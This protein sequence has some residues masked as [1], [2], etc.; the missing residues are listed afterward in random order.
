M[1]STFG[2]KC[3]GGSVERHTAPA[4]H[5]TDALQQHHD[6]RKSHSVNESTSNQANHSLTSAVSIQ[7][8]QTIQ[9][10]HIEEIIAQLMEEAVDRAMASAATVDWI[11][12]KPVVS[13]ESVATDTDLVP[14]YHLPD[15]NRP[16]IRVVANGL[17]VFPLNDS[18][19]MVCLLSYVDEREL[20]QYNARIEKCNMSISTVNNPGCTVTGVMWLMYEIG[21]RTACLP[22]IVMKA[23]RSHF[24]VGINFMKAFDI[25]FVWGDK[26]KCQQAVKPW[27]TP[28]SHTIPSEQQSIAAIETGESS[29]RL[30]PIEV[31]MLAVNKH[32]SSNHYGRLAQNVSFARTSS[33]N[34]SITRVMQQAKRHHR[35]LSSHYVDMVGVNEENPTIPKASISEAKPNDSP[36]EMIM[37]LLKFMPKK[38]F[39]VHEIAVSPDIEIAKGNDDTWLDVKPKKQTCVSEPHELTA[40]Q[41]VKLDAVLELFPYTPG[42]GPLNCTP[43]YTQTIDTGDA[44][45]EIRKQYPMSPYVLAEVEQEIKNLIDKDIIEPIDFSPWRWPILWVRK[46]TGGGRICIDARGLNKLTVRDAY[47][48]LRVDTILQNL[49]K[50]KFISCLDMTQAFH[51]IAIDPKDREKVAFAVGHRFYQF[52]RASMGFKNSPADLAKLLD[53]VF[54]DMMPRVYHYVDDFIILS[55]TFDEHLEVLTEVARRLRAAKLSIS[56]KKSLFCHKRIT[57]LGYVLTESGLAA[58]EERIKPILEYKRPTTVKE[59]R[60]LLGMVGWYRRFLPN[61]AETL[62]PL[63]DL[64]RGESK[65]KIAWNDDAEQAFE[66][67]K[68]ALMSPAVL[69]SPDYRLPY[70]IYTDA[71]LLAGAAVLTQVQDGEEKVIAFHSAKFSPAQRNYSATERE[72]LAVLAGVEKF[73][74][75][76]DGTSFTVV[77]DHASLKWLQNL[78]EPHGKLARWAVRLQAFDITFEHRPGKQMVVPD[79]LSRS[80]ELIELGPDL[81]TADRWYNSMYQL[82]TAGKVDRYKIVENRLYHLG[83][84][85][86]VTGERRWTLCVPKERVADVLAE[87]HDNNSHFGYWKTLRLIQKLYYW[88]NMHVTISEYVQKCLTCKLAKPSNENTRT[89][90]GKFHDPGYAGRVLSLDLVGPLPASKIHKHIWI[91]VVVD[92]FSRYVFAKAVTRATS[93]VIVDFLE[94][95]VFYRFDTPEILKTD[96]GTQ[97]TSELFA[98]FVADHQIL[99][100]KTPVYHPQSNPVEAT[101]KSVKQLLRIELLAKASHLDWSSYLHKV[102]MRLNTAPRHPTGQTP[103]FLVFGRERA[104][105]GTH[106]KLIHDVN[107]PVE[108]SSERR[109]FIEENVAEEQ[110]AAFEKNKRQYN[111]RATVRKFKAGDQVFV[112]LHKQSSAGEAYAQKLA[113]PKRVV[114]VKGLVE[115]ATDTYV[116]MDEQQ[117][118]IGTYHASDIYTK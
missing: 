34:A 113:A 101:N 29:K 89:P 88:P 35:N 36:V 11:N 74:P 17:E 117:R 58:N 33:T 112:R 63:S 85:D 44:K 21:H 75:Y 105:K 27:L 20:E 95:E 30:K 51:Q 104:V 40:E 99:H 45:P 91:I 60:R 31:G 62:A 48:T 53:R 64:T 5:L 26:C 82:A 22:T 67:V 81:K 73:R 57:F 43:L 52:K 2:K 19:S 96:N 115:N 61:I 86:R 93:N 46:K 8:T 66:G 107:E 25:Q 39:E 77:T 68:A 111:L 24:I 94:K 70:K 54:G 79:A 50:A 1:Q 7:A 49:P 109:E 12:L 23:H 32:V 106:H 78:K 16:Y 100:I 59:L 41:Q 92:T 38:A 55:A 102:V 114:F 4:E 90:T 13:V 87:Q 56:K 37:E 80:V 10:I 97:F 108:Q 42:T 110:R 14:I 72:C 47:P 9:P 76:I 3:Q 28:E 84:F 103:H 18:G 98:K 83:K 6:F 71:S 65:S 116:L 118:E 15:D 69:T